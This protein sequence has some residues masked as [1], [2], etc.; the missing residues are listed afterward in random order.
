M[1]RLT[2]HTYKMNDFSK[3]YLLTHGFRYDKGSLYD[4]IDTYFNRFPVLK[5]RNKTPL[6]ECV[7]TT[8]SVDG[9][10]TLNVYE[11]T[12]NLYTLFYNNEYGRYDELL[13]KINTR[14]LSEFS[15]LGIIE[16]K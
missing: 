11:Q 6:L 3:K 7:L 10:I 15:K 16:V 1:D 14:I 5:Y 12:G 9:I 4:D 2:E 8:N 13:T